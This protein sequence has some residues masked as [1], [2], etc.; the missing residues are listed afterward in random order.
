MGES[1]ERRKVGETAGRGAHRRH[2]KKKS[3]ERSG[4]EAGGLSTRYTLLAT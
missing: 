1:E 3:E 2:G 4:L